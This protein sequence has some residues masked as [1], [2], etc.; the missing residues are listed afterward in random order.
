MSYCVFKVITKYP[1]EQHIPQ[2]V[3]YSTM[4]KYGSNQCEKDGNGCK[5]QARQLYKLFGIRIN[6][7]LAVCN[8]IVGGKYLSGYGGKCISEVN[9]TSKGLVVYEYEDIYGNKQVIYDGSG[10]AVP[11]VITY[12]N[13]HG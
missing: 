4:H 3:S 5:L 7:H 1:E 11:V 9:V 8:N 10:F 13:K 6:Q 2:K 12:G